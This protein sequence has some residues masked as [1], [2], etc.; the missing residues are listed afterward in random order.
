[1]ATPGK[2]KV[3]WFF[4]A[5]V[6][7]LIERVAFLGVICCK[8][9]LSVEYLGLHRVYRSSLTFSI[10]SLSLEELSIAISAYD[11]LRE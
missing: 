10:F 4:G 2:L 11:F 1:M 8:S 3:L 6:R 9:K 7:L 5:E